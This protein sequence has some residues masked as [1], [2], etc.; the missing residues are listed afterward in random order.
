MTGVRGVETER[1]G[2]KLGWSGAERWAGLRKIGRGGAW[3]GGNGAVSRGQKNQVYWGAAKPSAPLTCSGYGS[4][5]ALHFAR[6]TVPT[7]RYRGRQAYEYHQELMYLSMVNLHIE[8]RFRYGKSKCP[9]FSS[10]HFGL[11]GRLGLGVGV[12]TSICLVILCGGGLGA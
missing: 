8:S 5:C 7:R 12:K 6:A 4:Q 2:P 11:V 9:S 10:S 3:V 1:S